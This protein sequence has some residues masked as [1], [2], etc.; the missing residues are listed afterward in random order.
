MDQTGR[1]GQTEKLKTLFSAPVLKRS[2]TLNRH[3]TSVSLEEPFWEEIKAIAKVEDVS[4]NALISKVDEVR[5]PISLSS[6]LRLYSLHR[7]RD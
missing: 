3:R 2:V 7:L 5:G 6:A 4:L 1:N